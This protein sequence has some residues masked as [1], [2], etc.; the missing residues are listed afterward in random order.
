MKKEKGKSASEKSESEIKSAET[1]IFRNKE[2]YKGDQPWKEP[3]FTPEKEYYV[4]LI[5]QVILFCQKML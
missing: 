1:K 5:A 4:H 2:I 3:L